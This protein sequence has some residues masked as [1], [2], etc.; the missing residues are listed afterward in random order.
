MEHNNHCYID[1]FEDSHFLITEFEHKIEQVRRDIERLEDNSTDIDIMMGEFNFNIDERTR[2]LKKYVE[3]AAS[4]VRA[5]YG[6]DLISKQSN[7]TRKIM[8]HEAYLEKTAEY[9]EKLRKSVKDCAVF[10]IYADAKMHLDGCSRETPQHLFERPAKFEFSPCIEYQLTNAMMQFFGQPQSSSQSSQQPPPQ[11]EASIITTFLRG[12]QQSSAHASNSSASGSARPHSS[13]GRVTTGIEEQ[14][15]STSSTSSVPV[16]PPGL[17]P[18]P[19]GARRR[20]QFHISNT[21]R[22]SPAVEALFSSISLQNQSAQNDEAVH[23]GGNPNSS[24]ASSS[25]SVTN[26]SSGTANTAP[27]I[28]TILPNASSGNGSSVSSDI[29]VT[30]P[31]APFFLSAVNTYTETTAAQRIPS[32]SELFNMTA[33]D[34]DSGAETNFYEIA[35]SPIIPNIQ[36]TMPQEWQP[37]AADDDDNVRRLFQSLMANAPS[38]SDTNSGAQGPRPSEYIIPARIVSPPPSSPAHVFNFVEGTNYIP[39]P[40]PPSRM[41]HDESTTDSDMQPERPFSPSHG[42]EETLL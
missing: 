32:L 25:S 2:K 12:L 15:P 21:R 38:S 22:A 37:T 30:H 17:S 1:V 11:S 7:I 40:A 36:N 35:D 42:A 26:T 31:L 4:N 33:S 28:R 3:K 16:V 23:S 5:M 41:E 9:L 29:S 14:V 8:E 6:Q 20:R 24:S 13:L 10:D 27:L 19:A 39:T 18:S 34:A